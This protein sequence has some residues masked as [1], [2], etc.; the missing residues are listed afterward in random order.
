MKLTAD[1]SLAIFSLV[2]SIIVSLFAVEIRCMIGFCDT[3]IP[4]EI[5][6]A[7]TTIEPT[8]PIPNS[9]PIPTI[10]RAN[11]SASRRQQPAS[12]DRAWIFVGSMAYLFAYWLGIFLI[13]QV[14]GN[15]SGIIELTC[16]R[17][18]FRP[19]LIFA[20]L[21]AL[22]NVWSMYSGNSSIAFFLI[23]YTVALKIAGRD[24]LLYGWFS[25]A[26]GAVVSITIIGV[27]LAVRSN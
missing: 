9:S 4:V 19:S 17:D 14:L 18:A 26:W 3:P 22:P 5:G 6:P 12:I 1:Q 27:T 24:K 10:P 8:Q 13:F 23:T 21:A 15:I 25:A 11:D 7:P 20:L 16:A 2:I